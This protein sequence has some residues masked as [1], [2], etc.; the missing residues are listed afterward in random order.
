M[1]LAKILLH[2]S[3]EIKRATTPQRQSQANP[4]HSKTQRA[5]T[6]LK[7][8][9]Y[10][11][12]ESTIKSTKNLLLMPK[13]RN[14]EHLPKKQIT[15]I[16]RNPIMSNKP[17]CG[18]PLLFNNINLS[19]AKKNTN[20]KK[21]FR[22][23]DD[24]ECKKRNHSLVENRNNKIKKD[25]ELKT[26]IQNETKKRHDMN[27]INNLKH[28]L[29]NVNNTVNYNDNNNT[30]STTPSSNRKR[31]SITPDKPIFAISTKRSSKEFND[32]SK[33]ISSSKSSSM[34]NNSLT[35]PLN[36]SNKLNRLQLNN[37]MESIE[38]ENILSSQQSRR[39]TDT[40]TTNIKT[41]KKVIAM[42]HQTNIGYLGPDIDKV[43]Q[44]SLFITKNFLS[45]SSNYFIGVCDG[46]GDIGHIISNHISINL[47]KML[48]SSLSS[49]KIALSP[50]SDFIAQN[51]TSTCL[52]LNKNITSL[53]TMDC[54]LSGSTCT[55]VIISPSSM[56]CINVG[57]SR[58]V[59]GRYSSITNT[60]FSEDL[61]HDHKPENPKEKERIVSSGGR[62]EQLKDMH[63]NYMG[64]F[65]MWM[66][67]LNTPGLAMSR[68]FGDTVAAGIGAI[69]EPEI[70]V[71]EFTKED[72]FVIL[73]SDGIW[74]FISSKECVKIVGEYYQ[75]KDINGAIRTIC[76][77]AKK[78]W[79]KEEDMR[80]DITCIIVF[81]NSD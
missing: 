58:T 66:K 49:S 20:F 48:S 63:G 37:I 16:C 72:R 7:L 70:T 35:T 53:Q 17:R 25:S 40:N 44:D 11:D 45:C 26:K 30:V 54:S 69:C 39:R 47:P 80:D 59:L 15:S 77:V 56:I 33:T 2:L 34:N 76:D 64:P 62:V 41:N 23:N 61:S 68:S 27:E 28:N 21:D 14:R 24:S 67:E 75:R 22:T 13:S 51:I 81:F 42:N 29:L 6:P 55:S 46:H 5:R 1:S 9:S 19:A 74:E 50:F 4:T 73:A 71:H 18:M 12:N 43:N 78:R 38:E 60:F 10:K 36:S 8:Q 32:E 52:K 65:R 79:M 31:L 57:D 3:H